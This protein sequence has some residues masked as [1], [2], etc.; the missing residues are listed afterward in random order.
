MVYWVT[1]SMYIILV[2]FCRTHAC[3]MP[4]CHIQC[5][6]METHIHAH[7]HMAGKVNKLWNMLE[8]YMYI[9]FNNRVFLRRNY[10]L[11]VA[12]TKFDV[13]KRDICPR[14]KASRAYIYASIK[15]IKFPRGNYQTDSSETRTLCRLSFLFTTKFSSMRAH[16]KT[17]IFNYFF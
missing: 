15:N 10:W 5:H 16:S 13:L 12:P 11:I 2:Y 8:R 3:W 9:Y 6:T 4:W 17:R 7:M 1:F 14:S